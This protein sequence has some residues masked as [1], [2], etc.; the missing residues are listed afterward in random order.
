MTRA[1]DTAP[2]RGTLSTPGTHGSILRTCADCIV[3]SAS[4]TSWRPKARG[5]FA[6]EGT[7]WFS[8]GFSMPLRS[9]MPASGPSGLEHRAALARPA[10]RPA[11]RQSVGRVSPHHGV[12]GGRREQAGSQTEA[13]IGIKNGK[14]TPKP[15]PWWATLSASAI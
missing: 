5:Q 11:R 4:A 14:V 2:V 1:P 7:A 6:L 10:R 15:G 12:Q 3:S 13:E 9:G 8:G